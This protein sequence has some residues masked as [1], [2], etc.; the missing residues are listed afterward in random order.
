VVR[1]NYQFHQGF[2]FVA[3][4]EEKRDKIRAA[5]AS[6]TPYEGGWY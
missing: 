3:L 4:S 5:C 6:L 2:E 1:H